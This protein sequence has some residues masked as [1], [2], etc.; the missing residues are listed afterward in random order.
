MNT[1]SAWYTSDRVFEVM[2][3]EREI[4][5]SCVD[6]RGDPTGII[7]PEETSRAF[8]QRVRVYDNSTLNYIIH[9]FTVNVNKPMNITRN[10]RI[11]RT[12]GLFNGSK[13][14]LIG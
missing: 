2:L 5:E 13:P 14:R 3:G 7:K 10:P 8:V 11:S 9:L 4:L 6:L 12:P 1:T